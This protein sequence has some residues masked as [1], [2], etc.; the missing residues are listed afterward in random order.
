MMSTSS[1]THLNVLA[2]AV[3]LL[4][5]FGAAAACG[6][7]LPL[8][9]A[10]PGYTAAFAPQP[11]KIVVGQHFK[12]DVAVCPDPGQPAATAL[13]VD[14]DMPAHRHG[15]NYRATVKGAGAQRWQAEGLMFHMPGRWRF[16]FELATPQGVRK[17]SQEVEVE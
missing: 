4:T 9:A 2:T 3:A 16:L 11:A 10:G 8:R 7:G 17:L 12:L 6:D 13:K 1:L 5:A 14:A 15:M